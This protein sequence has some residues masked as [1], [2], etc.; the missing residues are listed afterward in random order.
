MVKWWIKFV[1]KQWRKQDILDAVKKIEVWDF[2]WLDIT[3]ISWKNNHYRCRIW[4]VRIL[5]YEENSKYY[6]YGVGM[7]WS[8]Y[9]GI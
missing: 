2:S 3:S 8:I 6:I 9:K 5:F 7:R 4:K 1:R